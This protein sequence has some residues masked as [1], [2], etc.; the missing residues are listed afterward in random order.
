MEHLASWL[1]SSPLA[2]GVGGHEANRRLEPP[3]LRIGSLDGLAL[4]AF[5]VVGLRNIHKR[6]DD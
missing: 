3:W 1:A 6:R 2:E 4:L 5:A